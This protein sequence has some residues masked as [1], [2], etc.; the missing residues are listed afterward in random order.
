[1]NQSLQLVAPCI[2]TSKKFQ[3]LPN[4]ALFSIFCEP[5]ILVWVEETTISTKKRKGKG[6]WV[7]DRKVFLERYEKYMNV[8]TTSNAGI[9]QILF[10]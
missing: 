6:S 1:M 5:E 2:S 3:D 7:Q 4:Q 8:L 10:L 9:W